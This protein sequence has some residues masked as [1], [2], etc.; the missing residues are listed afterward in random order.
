M[1]KEPQKK[2]LVEN[3]L[4]LGDKAFRELI[5]ILPKEWLHLDLTMSQL[6]VPF[7]YERYRL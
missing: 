4:Q 2:E 3:I 7:S 6:K 5:P 1:A